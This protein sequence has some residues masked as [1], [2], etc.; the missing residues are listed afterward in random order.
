MTLLFAR[1][2]A[3]LEVIEPERKVGNETNSIVGDINTPEEASVVIVRVMNVLKYWIRECGYI[4]SDILECTE[5]QDLLIAFLIEIIR[6][7]KM[8]SLHQHAEILF[9]KIEE[10]RDRSIHSATNSGRRPRSSSRRRRNSKG[11][12]GS[13]LPGPPKMVRGKTTGSVAE[14][15]S[16]TRPRSSSGDQST[17]S[18]TVRTKSKI[19][20][21]SQPLTGISAKAAAEQLTLIESERYFC[22]LKNRELTNRAWT[23]ESK[24]ED[25]PG[26]LSMIELFDA[27][28]EW[29]SSEILHPKLQ[30]VE[31]AKMMSYF[32][33]V[34]D[35]CRI[36]HN[37]NTLFEIVT[38]LNAPCI[39]QLH[40]TWGLVPSSHVEKFQC[41]QQICSVEDNYKNYR[42]AFALGEGQARLPCLFV[43]AKDLYGYEESMQAIEHGLVHFRKF[44]KVMSVESYVIKTF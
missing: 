38:G 11:A 33:D 8:P 2:R 22:R 31:R 17:S 10:V 19:G 7:I 43:L 35:Y 40:T 23:R 44:Q 4:E 34:A 24:R 36:L 27:R 12:K 20:S 28:A 21:R 25:A 42:Q 18:T 16:T 32:I 1:Y 29:V 3:A 5:T 6:T 41:L 37:Y 30:T 13:A 14:K 9:A 39:K 26:V 15:A